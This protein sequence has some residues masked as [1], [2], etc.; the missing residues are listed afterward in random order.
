MSK[1]YIFLLIG[2]VLVLLTIAFIVFVKSIGS[3]DI[4]SKSNEHI[5]KFSKINQKLYFKSKAWGLAG[6]NEKIILSTNKGDVK[7]KA[8]KEEDYIFHTTE[9]YYKQKGKDTLVIYVNESSVSIP[10][11]FQSPI[12]VVIKGLKNSKELNEYE[13]NYKKYGLVK[14][15]TFE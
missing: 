5:V 13:L 8:N 2:S 10:T 4:P 9:L 14:V 3:V 12:L 7:A 11:S 1:K 6:N 15:S